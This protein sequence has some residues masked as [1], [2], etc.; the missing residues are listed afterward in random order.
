MKNLTHTQAFMNLK[1]SLEKYESRNSNIEFLRILSMFLILALHANYLSIGWPTTEEA[2]IKPISTFVRVSFEE[3]CI[4]CV[5]LF[6]LISGWFSIKIKFKSFI[7]FLFQCF[8]I[9]ILMYA[10][11]LA[12]SKASLAPDSILQCF[13]LQGNA[14][15]VMAYLGLYI[16]SPFLNHYCEIASK[17]QLKNILIIFFIFQTI[18]GDFSNNVTFIDRGFSTFS[19]IGLY[20]LAR[21]IRLHGRNLIKRPLLLYIV[22]MIGLIL[23]YWIPLRLGFSQISE[24]ALRYT[25]PLNITASLG[26]IVYFANMKMRHNVLINFVAASVFS[27]YLCHICNNW[28]WNLYKAT[29][30]DAYYD[31]PTT[32]YFIFIILFIIGVFLFGIII[33]QIRKFV[34]NLIENTYCFNQFNKKIAL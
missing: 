32:K 1:L 22:S 11:G 15:F 18:Y 29:C 3:I 16:L 9:I 17:R 25:C 7:G 33:D 20:L 34:W 24:M 2:V 27:V 19:F 28:T 23:W 5:N 31:M 12:L 14:W 4:I 30:Q 8:F 13:M 6:V 26:L 10:V 21:F